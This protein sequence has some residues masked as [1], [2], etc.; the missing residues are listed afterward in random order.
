VTSFTPVPPGAR[1][2]P[3]E[4]YTAAPLIEGP[5][6][7]RTR[8]RTFGPPLGL[9]VPA[10]VGAIAFLSLQWSDTSWSG[11]VGLIGGV[12]AA[13]CLL[14]VGAPFGDDGLYGLAIGASVLLWIL[15]GF[16]A[17]R[18]ATRSPIATWKDYWRHYAWMCGGIWV[19]CLVALGIAAFVISD[20]LI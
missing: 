13:P 17:A 7:Y 11:A 20:P 19:G 18:R 10:V 15:V 12:F 14:L 4:Q 16:L 8:I 2:A 3:H 5:R 6:W 1:P 9:L